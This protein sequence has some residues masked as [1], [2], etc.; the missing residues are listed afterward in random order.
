MSRSDIPPAAPKWS[1]RRAL[2]FIV[3]V[4]AALWAL[5]GYVAVQIARA[6]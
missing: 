2:A 1:A 5:I 3:G 4:S 6:L